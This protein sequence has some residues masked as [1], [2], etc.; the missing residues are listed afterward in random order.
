MEENKPLFVS[1]GYATCHWC[2]V[3]AI[4]AFSDQETAGYLNEHF[5]CIKVDREQRPDIDQ[6]LMEFINKQNGR[7]GWPL[8]VF[9]TPDL[10]PIFALTYAPAVARN[11][12]LSFV[13]VSEQVNEYYNKN[14]SAIPAFVSTEDKPAAADEDTIL[15]MLSEYYD[16]ENGGFGKGQKFPSHSTLLYLLYQIS[17][18]NSPSIKTIITKTLGTMYRRGLHDHLQGGI[19]RYCVDP[20]WTIPHF[21]KMLYDQ[22]MAL[23]IYSLAYRV[24][25]TGEYKTMAEG[26]LRCL[27]E[28][29]EVKGLYIS[30]HDADTDHEEGATYLW[31]YDQLKNELQPEDFEKFAGSYHITKHGNFEGL[32]HLIRINDIPLRQIEEKLLSIRRKRKQPSQDGKIVSG[33]NALVAIAL[34]E[35]GRLLDKPELEKKAAVIIN[36]IIGLFW[37][38]S[39]LGHSYFNGILQKQP[40]LSD[41]APMLVAIAMLCESDPDK[42]PLMNQFAAYV[43]SFNDAGK[44]VESESDDFQKVYASWFDHPIP[45]S[46]SLA[47]MGLMRAAVLSGKDISYRDYLQ[48]F[49]SDFYN[50]IAMMSNGFFHLYTTRQFIPW[51][52]LP[53]NLIQIRGEHETECYMGTCQPLKE[54]G[55]S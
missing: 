41:A 16:A 11:S 17:I 31:S 53:V 54:P 27:D 37:D 47:E 36:N 32:N 33:I 44:W 24:T 43:Q 8:N 20:G 14:S 35:A 52:K 9:L 51:N 15:E 45:S 6:L 2:H 23:W 40:F 34:I 18:D 48:P 25:G 30:A 39:I 46:A 28:S 49:Q 1:V 22:A 42:I 50:I 4:E 3:M 55:K 19:F 13:S 29:F 12:M 10:H 38:G 21:E 5:I 26:I 7:G